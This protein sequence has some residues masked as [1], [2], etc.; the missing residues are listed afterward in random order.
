MAAFQSS[1]VR[2]RARTTAPFAVVR[3]PASRLLVVARLLR[4]CEPAYTNPRSISHSLAWSTGNA[5][6]RRTDQPAAVMIWAACSFKVFREVPPVGVPSINRHDVRRVGWA[7]SASKS[8][9]AARLG[10]DQLGD[11]WYMAI[12]M[13]PSVVAS[14]LMMR[15]S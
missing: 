11:T 5:P 3:M 6:T 13:F 1:V 14:V 4:L 2:L 12:V 10:P 7:S 9:D 15:C 8:G